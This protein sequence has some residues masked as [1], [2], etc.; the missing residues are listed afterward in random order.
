[1]SRAVKTAGK[2]RQLC[3]WLDEDIPRANLYNLLSRHLV[4]LGSP[5]QAPSSGHSASETICVFARPSCWTL[6]PQTT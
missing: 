2:S 4:W 1:M 6:C 5:G 3:P